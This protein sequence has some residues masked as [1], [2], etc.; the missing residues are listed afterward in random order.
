MHHQNYL[1][2]Q[3]KGQR[4]TFQLEE[5]IKKAFLKNNFY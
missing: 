3:G 4:I 2:F 1:K 5:K